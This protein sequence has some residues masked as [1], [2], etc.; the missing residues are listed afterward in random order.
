MNIFI[1]GGT[2]FIGSY[3]RTMLLQEGHFLTIVTRSPAKYESEKAKNQRF[4]SWDDDF[5]R[6]MNRAD[7]VINL[8]GASI[9][10]QRWTEEV[11]DRIYES[12]IESTRQIVDAIK[13]ADAPPKVLVSGSAAGYYGDRGEEVLDESAPAG[14]DFLAQVCVDWEKEARKVEETGV[15]LV[16]PR[17]GIVLQHKGAAL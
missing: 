3:L 16:T 13:K 6:E 8:A 12:R 5:V 1:T 4:I 2:G 9:F 15:R 10:G 17:I 14:D 7:G 11:K